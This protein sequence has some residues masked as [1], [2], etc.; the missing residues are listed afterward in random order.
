VTDWYPGERDDDAASGVPGDEAGVSDLDW[1]GPTAT[2]RAADAGVPYAEAAGVAP[3]A[4]ERDVG[5]PNS[6]RGS[7]S[8]SARSARG[9]G[10]WGLLVLSFV[11]GAAIGVGLLV[12]QRTTLLADIRAI[13]RRLEASEAS[14]TA[15]GQQVTDLEA[16]LA[17]SEASTAELTTQNEALNAELATAK[18]ALAAAQ[19]T[20]VTIT[21]RTASPASVDASHSITLSAKVQGAADKVQM[22]VVGTGTISYS[23]TYNLTKGTTTGGITTW[24]RKV[25]APGKL[26]VYRYYATAYVGTK[27]TEMPGVTA[28]TFTVK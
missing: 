15:A 11:I 3:V 10:F 12:W 25:T 28:W 27:K 8:M 21:E 23:K 5:R 16:R 17:S 7:R 20:A 18:A 6:S 14:A 22:K 1:S 13:E 26:G 24:S 19:S 2:S 9:G 4:D